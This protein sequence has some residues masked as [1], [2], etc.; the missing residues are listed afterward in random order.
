MKKVLMTA[1]CLTVLGL[2][3]VNVSADDV[4]DVSADMPK[5]E[6]MK[7]DVNMKRPHRKNMEDR[8]AER[9][10][11]TDEQKK[12]SEEIRKAGREK[13]KP[14]IEESKKISE[15][16]KEIRSQNMQEFEKILTDEQKVE[17]KKFQEERKGP[18][19]PMNRGK[20]PEKK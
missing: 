19:R 5:A 10:K 14:L 8:L 7:A 4:K 1:V 16:M 17:F 15:K 9:L 3:A 12:Q 6:M 2:G 13:M 11:L 20:H 18:R